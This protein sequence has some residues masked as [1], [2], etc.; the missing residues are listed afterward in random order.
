MLSVIQESGEAVVLYSK[1][2]RFSIELVFHS[3]GV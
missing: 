3:P 2:F 1:L